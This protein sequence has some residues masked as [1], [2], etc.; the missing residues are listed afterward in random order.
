MSQDKKKHKNKVESQTIGQE[1]AAPGAGAESSSLEVGPEPALVEAEENFA[2]DQ[3]VAGSGEAAGQF[4]LEPVVIMPEP[5]NSEDV[6]LD[7]GDQMAVLGVEEAVDSV[8]PMADDAPTLAQLAAPAEE[9]QANV[10]VASASVPAAPAAA[11]VFET[12]AQSQPVQTGFSRRAVLTWLFVGNFLTLLLAL[13]ITLGVLAN[14]NNGAL[15]FAQPSDLAPL[16][17]RLSGLEAGVD[18]L[19]RDQAAIR[20]RLD[21]LESLS[22]RV[23]EVEKQTS[24]TQQGLEAQAGEIEILA[25]QAISLTVQVDA[26]NGDLVEIEGQVI[27]LKSASSRYQ[28]F[29]DG[30][31]ELLA[32]IMSE[33]R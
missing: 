32:S 25:A 6:E 9:P 21:N 30:L 4:G 33:G 7:S 13:A 8:R 20:A 3:A 2:A 17:Q 26:L 10:P 1:P 31:A 28:Q 16:D 23:G 24:Q 12:A 18:Q 15:Q 19:N 14:L 29:L 5:G 27:E 22:A 11:P